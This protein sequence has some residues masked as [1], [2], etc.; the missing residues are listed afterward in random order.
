MTLEAIQPPQGVSEINATPL[1]SRTLPQQSK[2]KGKENLTGMVRGKGV[3]ARPEADVEDRR[4]VMMASLRNKNKKKGY[5]QFLMGP[6]PKKIVFGQEEASEELPERSFEAGSSSLTASA[7]TSAPHSEVNLAALP[8][9]YQQ[10]PSLIPPSEIQ[11]RGELPPNMFVTSIDVEADLWNS[12][13]KKKKNRKKATIDVQHQRNPAFANDEEYEADLDVTLSYD[14]GDTETIIEAM[15]KPPLTPPQKISEFDWDQAERCFDNATKVTQLD[16]LKQV[17]IVGW[18]VR[19][20]FL[21][22]VPAC[23]TEFDVFEQNLELN[24]QTFTPEILLIAGKVLEV[25]DLTSSVKVQRLLR[26]V[27]PE[28]GF[29]GFLAPAEPGDEGEVEGEVEE[30]RWIDIE[31]LGWRVLHGL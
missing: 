26:P 29:S 17:L 4:E 5:K 15:S 28:S 2:S 21:P 23:A 25:S 31:S 1:G 14:N 19:Y 27:N 24:P 16:Q 30:Y 7:L 10:L 12:N 13:G 9:E 22:S 20:S 6:V 11:E 18:K 3:G 8:Q